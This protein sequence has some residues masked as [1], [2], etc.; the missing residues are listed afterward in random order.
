LFELG[1]ALRQVAQRHAQLFIVNERIDL[2]LLLGAD[3]LHLRE[4]S[5]ETRAARR[6][7]GD[8]PIFRACHRVSELASLDAD[9]AFLSPVLEARKGSAPLGLPALGTARDA[10]LA[11]GKRTRLFALGGVDAARAGACLEA[12]ADG[13]AAIGSALGEVSPLP[14]LR[15][16]G[17]A[18]QP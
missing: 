9:A 8:L 15:A 17:I 12:G 4:D 18:K 1:Q 6:L 16:L 14:L 5:V 3:A 11:A 7:C 13:V 10:L 2:A